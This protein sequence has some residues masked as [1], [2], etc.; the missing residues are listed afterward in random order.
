MDN[1]ADPK[2]IE[3][4][5]GGNDPEIYEDDQDCNL[6]IESHRNYNTPE[7]M[8][9]RNDGSAG[10]DPGR[11]FAI[12]HSIINSGS[13][14]ERF[15]GSAEDLKQQRNKVTADEDLKEGGEVLRPFPV[16]VKQSCAIQAEDSGEEFDDLMSFNGGRSEYLN[17]S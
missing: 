16:P 12:P 6:N 15:E 1:V 17:K 5:L 3:I 9:K 7:E 11:N 14:A 8:K 2:D 4:D 10:K 13:P